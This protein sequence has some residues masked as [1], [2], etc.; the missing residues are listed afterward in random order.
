MFSEVIGT[1]KTLG[2]SLCSWVLAPAL[3]CVLML[4]QALVLALVLA[5]ALT[6]SLVLV[7]TSVRALSFVLALFEVVGTQN[8]IILFLHDIITGGVDT[9]T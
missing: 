2:T 9:Q 5:L 7:L 4:P 8:Q 1:Q 3:G 6:L